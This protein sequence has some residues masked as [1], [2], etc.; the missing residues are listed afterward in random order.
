MC[1]TNFFMST[2]DRTIASTRADSN[3][4]AG[5]WCFDSRENN[6]L[7]ILL[8]SVL[9]VLATF[10]T[11]KLHECQMRDARDTQNVWRYAAVKKCLRLIY[12]AEHFFEVRTVPSRSVS[13]R[14]ESFAR[15][16]RKTFL[17]VPTITAPA[18]QSLIEILV[19]YRSNRMVCSAPNNDRIEN[20]QSVFLKIIFHPVVIT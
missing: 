4:S 12:E 2:A 19:G 1:E 18:K 10:R 11:A 14:I 3:K 16:A 5:F 13:D 8:S 17:T 6:T 7:S 15:S 9:V 20:T